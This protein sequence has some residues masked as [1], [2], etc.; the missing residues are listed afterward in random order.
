MDNINNFNLQQEFINNLANYERDKLLNEN[1][2]GEYS[3]SDSDDS[4]FSI[5]SN[6]ME[7]EKVIIK[8]NLIVVSSLDRDWYNSS[9]ENPFSF[10]VKLGNG[11][12][13]DFSF[14]DYEPKNII[15]IGVD[16]LLVSAR[17]YNNS[18][19]LN[20]VNISKFPFLSLSV[21]N[22]DGV[23]HSTN[24]KLNKALA[25]MIPFTPSSTTVNFPIIEYKN[26]LNHAKEFYNN[27]MASLGKLDIN[28]KD[29][30]DV[31][32]VVYNDVL[33]IKSITYSPAV[34]SNVATEYLVVETS[35]HF[36]NREY[37]LGDTLKFKNYQNVN[38]GIFSD[39]KVFNN[40]INRTDGHIV[41]DTSKTDSDKFLSNRIHIPI[42][43]T[44]STST[45]NVE[46]ETWYTN[47]KSTSLSN[48]SLSGSVNDLGGKLINSNLQNTIIFRIKTIEKESNFMNED[49]LQK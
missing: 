38:T 31:L 18:Y 29:Q 27:P 3:E 19:S 33:T 48:V 45:G 21:D 41:L 6:E 9:A 35:T 42:P 26:S 47:F 4:V 1:E 43:S 44:I 30:N 28:I 10:N 14:V 11:L 2:T 20:G 13:N 7:L 17:N 12:D 37:G 46:E 16:S 36:S 49:N 22:I 5:K 24:N 34:S 23:F 40:F 32:P 25:L 8:N 15:S 39:A